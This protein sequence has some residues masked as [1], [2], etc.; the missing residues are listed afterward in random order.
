[1]KVLNETPRFSFFKSPVSNTTPNGEMNLEQVH[2]LITGETYMKITSEMHSE[3]SKEVKGKL[4]STSLDYVCFSG[5][6]SKRSNSHLTSYSGYLVLDLDDLEHP[7]RVR[8][9]LSSDETIDWKLIFVSPSGNGLKV[10]VKTDGS[11]VRHVDYFMAYSNYL[12]STYDLI[13]DPSGKDLSRACF[14]CF[15][16]ECLINNEESNELAFPYMEWIE[17]NTPKTSDKYLFESIEDAANEVVNQELDLTGDYHQWITIGLALSSE[18]G[19]RGRT[20]FHKFSSLNASYSTVETDKKYSGFLKSPGRGITIKS[21]FYLLQKANIRIN[22]TYSS[23]PL[24]AGNKLELLEEWILERYKLRYNELRGTIE[25]C[26]IDSSSW[27]IIND[28]IFNSI[29]IQIKKDGIRCTA[30][31]L[32]S[33]INSDFVEGFHPFRDYLKLQEPWDG[34]DHIEMLADSIKAQNPDFWEIALKRWLVAF[35]ASILNPKIINQQVIVLCGGQGIGKTTWIMNLI[36]DELKEYTFS[37]TINPS[38]KDSLSLI[39]EMILINLDEMDNMNRNDSGTLKSLITTKQVTLRRAYG[40]F[41]ETK[42]RIASFVG[43]V[44]D[45]QFLNDPTGSRR[46]LVIDVESIDYQLE[47][48]LG[49]VYQQAIHLFEN[50]FK[51]YFDKEDIELIEENN[52][53]FQKT[54]FEEELLLKYFSPVEWSKEA[55]LRTATEILQHFNSYASLSLSQNHANQIGKA[56]S[57]NGFKKGKSDGVY[58]WAVKVKV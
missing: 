31:L 54:S 42:P 57:K 36:P 5:I 21:L 38:N 24:K 13:V 37:G 14:L 47:F 46:F 6:F 1:M 50:G 39:A 10:V 28:R 49:Q 32:N 56:L 30:D 51:Y 18:F 11:Q 7:E 43:S 27:K 58:K 12:L 19:E 44:N 20:L 26:E 16:P 48:N 9:K 15:D 22:E 23:K 29:L 40:R 33:L 2:Q 35:V 41:N 8:E 52:S 45:R 53:A 3:S 55:D 4:K 34:K 25:I 17:F